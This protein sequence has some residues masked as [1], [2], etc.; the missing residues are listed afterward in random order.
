MEWS[1]DT[2]L[3]LINLY[4]QNECL[5]N[6]KHSL[7]YNK[8]RKYDAWIQISTELNI[9]VEECKKKVTNLLSSFR[10]ER[11]KVKK[12]MGTR[13]DMFDYPSLSLQFNILYFYNRVR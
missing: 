2:I 9:A 5:W 4:K 10:R 6:A 12:S 3:L 13:K 7:Y 1:E 8:L 11:A